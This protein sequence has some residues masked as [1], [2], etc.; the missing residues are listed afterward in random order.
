MKY[1]IYRWL[2][3]W[4]SGDIVVYRII[5][6]IIWLWYHVSAR[7]FRPH[8]NLANSTS[9]F[10][11]FL[12]LVWINLLWTKWTLKHIKLFVFFFFF[13]IWRIDRWCGW[14]L[15]AWGSRST[16]VCGWCLACGSQL[17]AYETDSLD[18]QTDRSD[19][20][21]SCAAWPFQIIIININIIAS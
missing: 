5:Y 21:A 17:Q 10:S 12:S 20:R 19:C 16:V 13:A 8:L 9:Y 6:Y 11:A 18:R 4:G 1:I 3:L 7:L 14:G 2:H 15:R